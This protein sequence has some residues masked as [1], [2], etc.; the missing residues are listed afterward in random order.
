LK[1][2]LVEMDIPVDSVDQA[3]V[4]EQAHQEHPEMLQIQV[5]V[6]QDHQVQ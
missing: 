3:A 5:Q 6:A 1:A 4:A 2:F